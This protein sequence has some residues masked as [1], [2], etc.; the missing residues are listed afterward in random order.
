MQ[1]SPPYEVDGEEW[2]SFI[3]VHRKSSDGEIIAASIAEDP[4]WYQGGES[5]WEKNSPERQLEAPHLFIFDG[6][7]GGEL[8]VG[9]EVVLIDNR[10]HDLSESVFDVRLER[11]RAI[12]NRA[13]ALHSTGAPLEELLALEKRAEALEKKAEPVV[14]TEFK[15]RSARAQIRKKNLWTWM[16][17][18]PSIKNADKQA[19]KDGRPIKFGTRAVDSKITIVKA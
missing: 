3:Y 1:S 15:F 13:A 8:S 19:M 6:V 14:G 2:G 5:V 18:K 17:K 12:R 9:T 7:V 10:E 4:S 16:S 11:A